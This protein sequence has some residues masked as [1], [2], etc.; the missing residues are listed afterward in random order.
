MLTIIGISLA[1]CACIILYLSQAYVG[2][3][4]GTI[5]I[6][7][8]FGGKAVKVLKPGIGWMIWPYHAI[9]TRFRVEIITQ[10]IVVRANC[11]LDVLT[12]GEAPDFRKHGL[13]EVEC[14]EVSFQFYLATDELRNLEQLF[15][16]I[17]VRADG[18]IDFS[19]II[20]L[21]KDRIQTTLKSLLKDIG[22]MEA[23][24]AQAHMENQATLAVE[25]MIKREDLPIHFGKVVINRAFQPTD[26]ALAKAV[27]AKPQAALAR[28]AAKEE[29][30]LEVFQSEQRIKIARNEALATAAAIQGILNAFGDDLPHADRR[31]LFLKLRALETLQAMPGSKLVLSGNILQEAQ[32]L[33]ARFTG[34]K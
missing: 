18:T 11:L 16:V 33:I 5:T 10:N 34:G 13:I 6:I 20:E 29:M 30:A 1:V 19:K 32:A 26:P 2:T 22:L 7:R 9:L 25:V 17:T 8:N 31:E 28:S 24:L 14:T 3:P 15:R 21:I 27:A 23:A 4:A 12:P